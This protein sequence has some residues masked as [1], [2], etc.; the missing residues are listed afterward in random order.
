[1]SSGARAFITGIGGQDGS[2]LAELLLARG[3]EV[4]GLVHRPLA[5]RFE[6][7]EHLR[8]D[9]E[10]VAGDVRD[11]DLLSGVLDR[12]QPGELYHL[13]GPTFVPDALARPA[14]TLM[15]VAGGTAA[16]LEAAA[17]HDAPIR[18][19]VASSRE[20]FGDTDESPQRETTPCH[21]TN[22]YGIGK[23]AGHLLCGALRDQRGLHACSA[24][25]Y[26]HESPRRPEHFVTRK[27]TRGA[28]AIKLGLQ[29]ELVLGAL[30]AVRDWCF[31][32]DAMEAA[33]L[34]LQH[35]LPDDY[36]IASGVG[37]TVGELARVAFACVGLDADEYIRVDPEFVRAPERA[38][39][40]GDPSKARNVLGWTA[41]MSFEDM[42]DLM[43]QT[44]LERLSA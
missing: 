18:V 2:Y 9:L 20:I 29:S 17:S 6:N 30:E 31:A 16:V 25:L 36:V 39:P 12:W 35:D 4:C 32:A 40:I 37:R 5:E 42:V 44:D 15:A 1:V 7:I 22:P 3:Y 11:R 27:V 21:P 26:N 13:A 24:I 14:E 23:L 43:V 33:W 8:G 28:A 10:L 34:T 19:M 38:A 41:S